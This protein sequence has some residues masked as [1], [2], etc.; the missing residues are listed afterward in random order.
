M[1]H[2]PPVL[3]QLVAPPAD[4]Q[5]QPEGSLLPAGYRGCPEAHGAHSRMGVSPLWAGEPSLRGVL[6]R[7]PRA[8]ARGPGAEGAG[9]GTRPCSLPTA[10]PSSSRFWEK[11]PGG[12]TLSCPG[13][14]CHAA[15]LGRRA[16]QPGRLRQAAGHRAPSRLE[17]GGRGAAPGESCSRGRGS[18]SR[19]TVT[20][21]PLLRAGPHRDAP[22]QQGSSRNVFIYIETL[23][24][25]LKERKR[26]KTRDGFCAPHSHPTSLPPSSRPGP[27][28]SAATLAGKSL[29]NPGSG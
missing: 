10:S 3:L 28:A 4:L 11:I 24:Y 19:V 25:K 12:A 7:S 2:T 13:T 23:L 29:P 15:V 27:T 8:P 5:A 9:L 21:A 22:P 20:H 6:L 18:G 14:G 17:A 1:Q 26:R 16:S